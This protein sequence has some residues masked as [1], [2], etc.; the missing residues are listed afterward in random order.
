[1]S[2]SAVRV[3]SF[4][5]KSPFGAAATYTALVSEIPPSAA[6]NRQRFVHSVATLDAQQMFD[7]GWLLPLGQE[8]SLVDLISVYRQL[9]AMRFD[10]LAEESQP[11]VIRTLSRNDETLVYLANDSPWPLSVTMAVNAPRGTHAEKLGNSPGV[12]ALAETG[13]SVTWTVELRPYDLAGARFN[14]AGVKL[15]EPKVKLPE[16]AVAGLERQIRELRARA[17]GL[18]ARHRY[19]CL[20]IPVSSWRQ[21]RPKCQAGAPT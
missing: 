2:R 12:A 21:S 14:A 11:V 16:A 4:D 3:A 10:T 15:R 20:R 8:G 7:G 13:D 5:A 17:T 1:M 6:S 18:G 19:Q 9:P